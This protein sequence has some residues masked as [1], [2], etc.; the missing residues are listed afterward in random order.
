M[1]NDPDTQLMLYVK[2]GDAAAFQMLFDKYKKRVINYCYRFSGNLAVAEDLAQETFIRLYKGAPRY[3]PKAR[4]STWLFKIA[5]NVCL[6]ELRRPSYRNRMASIDDEEGKTTEEQIP[7]RQQSPA[8]DELARQQLQ[9]AV[10]AAMGQLPEKQRAALL[11][12]VDQEFSYREI[13]KQMGCRENHVKILIH[14][15]REKLKALLEQGNR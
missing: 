11:L 10:K 4:F 9:A 6:N 2:E 3:R 5:T 1:Q 14:R 13:A 8:D 7:D 15:A 12:R